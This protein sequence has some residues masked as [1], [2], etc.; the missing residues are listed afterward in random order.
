MN[1]YYRNKKAE[2]YD[3]PATVEGKGLSYVYNPIL[4]L[5]AEFKQDKVTIK[6][7]YSHLTA[8]DSLCIANTNALKYKF[9]AGEET[10]EGNIRQLDFIYNR[11]TLKNHITVHDFEEAI[12]IESFSLELEGL[13][14]VPLYLGLL[15]LGDRTTLPRFSLKPDNGLALTGSASRSFGGHVYGTKRITLD[16]IGVK[17]SELNLDE[18][19][20]I[21]DYILSV[22]NVEPHIIDPYPGARREFPP[23]YVTLINDKYSF[24]KTDDDGF[25]F[26]GSLSW[27]EAK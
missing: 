3:E 23:M 24:Q 9:T 22:Q 21:K 6:G 13:E 5:R 14:D 4:D 16:S 15:Y 26:S 17:F 11:I 18:Y 20:E 27:Q 2:F 7:K 12:F 1:I 19:K 10:V 25:Y 8:I